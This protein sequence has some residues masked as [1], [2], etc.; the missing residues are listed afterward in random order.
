[1]NSARPLTASR[2]NATGGWRS[3]VGDRGSGDRGFGDRGVRESHR[4]ALRVAFPAEW[5]LVVTLATAGWGTLLGLWRGEVGRA[6]WPA[7]G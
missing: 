7:T 6:G 5:H 1:L 2:D 4:P 3:E